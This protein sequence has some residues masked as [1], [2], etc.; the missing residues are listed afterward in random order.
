MIDSIQK[1][2]KLFSLL[3]QRLNEPLECYLIGGANLLA[4]GITTR[5][6]EDIDA[7]FPSYFSKHIKQHIESIALEYGLLPNWFNTMPSMD[8]KFLNEHWKERSIL[9]FSGNNLNIWLLNR[10]DIL[11]MKIAAALDRQK[12]DRH[13]ILSINPSDEEWEIARQ[14]ARKYDGHP[15]WAGLIDNLVEELKGLQKNA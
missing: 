1:I 9:F 11:G 3:D 13:D 4:Q 10:V 5:A 15:D 12:Q 8:E 14:W 2:K 6:T 7:V